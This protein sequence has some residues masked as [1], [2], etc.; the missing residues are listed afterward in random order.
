[1]V[2]ITVILFLYFILFIIIKP[3]MKIIKII[4]KSNKSKTIVGVIKRIAWMLESSTGLRCSSFRQ[5]CHHC[6]CDWTP[7]VF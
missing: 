2:C 1:M 7:E 6:S 5:S 4:N 3:N